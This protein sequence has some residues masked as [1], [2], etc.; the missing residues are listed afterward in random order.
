MKFYFPDSQDQVDPTFDFVTEERS[1][2]RVRQRDDRYAHEALQKP[3]FDGGSLFF[4][5]TGPVSRSVAMMTRRPTIGSLL[6]S[7][8]GKPCNN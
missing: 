2:F 8:R 3:P 1:I 7:C 4:G 6:S 5:T